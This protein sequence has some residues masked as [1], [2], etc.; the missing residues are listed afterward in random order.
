MTG[1]P[2]TLVAVDVTVTELAGEDEETAADDAIDDG[3]V[4]R[5][6]FGGIVGL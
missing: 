6:R 3:R 5:R 1:A 4:E 2:E